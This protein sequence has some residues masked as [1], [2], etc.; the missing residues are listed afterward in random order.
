MVGE[1]SNKQWDRIVDRRTS[2]WFYGVVLN[3]VVAFV[4]GIAVGKLL[5]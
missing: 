3:A 2:A 1:E 4:V 5:L